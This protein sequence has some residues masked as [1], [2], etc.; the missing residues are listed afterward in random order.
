MQNRGRLFV[1]EGVDA[2]GKSSIAAKFTQTLQN[3]GIES[4]ILA[5]PGN[6]PR[7]LGQLVYK[8]HHG[9]NECGIES[10]TPSSLQALHI[11]AH[12]D[13]IE[14][15]IIPSLS[16]GSCIVLDR[17]WWSTWAYGLV[18]GMQRGVLDALVEVERRAWG[19]W[20]PTHLFYVTRKDPLR[21]EPKKQWE[22]I[23]DAY[24]ELID[25]ENGKYPITIVENEESEIAALDYVLS[26][27]IIR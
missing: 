7:T 10:L 23:K 25:V 20:Q 22:M 16:R 12:L 11:A 5:F 17:Y 24:K 27:L 18:G 2:A 6:I 21:A 8:I 1:F 19:I 13:A 15:T 9:P 4:Q 26:H 14:T 3:R